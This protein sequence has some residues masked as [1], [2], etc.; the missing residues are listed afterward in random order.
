MERPL[1]TLIQHLRRNVSRSSDA[2]L[3]D[4]QLLERWTGQRDPAAFELLLWR[5]G[6]MVLNTCR[7]L[8]PRGEDAEDAFQA[9][10]LVFLRKGASLRRGDAL[11]AW[12]HRVAC[13]IALRARTAEIQ[14][15]KR[16]QPLVDALAAPH[17]D[18]QAARDLRAILDEEID[19]LPAHYRRALVLCCLEGKSQEEAAQML[20]CPRGTLSSWL[21]RGRERLRQR[22]LRRGIVVSSAGL[23]AALTSDALASGGMIPLVAS[24]IRVAGGVA[25][26]GLLSVRTI[27]L[28]EGMLRMMLMTKVKSVTAVLLVVVLLASG[29]GTIA[30]SMRAAESPVATTDK[31]RKT[32]KVPAMPPQGKDERADDIAWGAKGHGL[33]AG[34]GFRP[35]DQTTYEIGQSVTFVVYLRNVSDKKIALSHIE[36]LFNECMP[37]VEDADGNRLAVAH[38][39][40]NL[41]QVPIV[42]RSVKPGQQIT[43]GYPWFRIRELG[44]RGE[45]VGPTCGVSPGKYKVGYSGLLLRLNDGEDIGLGTK[46]VELVIRKGEAAKEV[47]PRDQAFDVQKAFDVAGGYFASGE[48]EKALHQYELIAKMCGTKKTALNALGETIRCFAVMGDFKRMKQRVE[49]IRGTLDTTEGLTDADRQ[50][51]LEWLSEVNKAL[52][53]FDPPKSSPPP[54]RGQAPLQR[55]FVSSRNIRIPVRILAKPREQVAQLILLVSRD[56][57]ETYQQAARISPT[58]NRFDFHAPGEGMY[59]FVVQQVDKQGRCTPANPSRV[60]PTLRVCVDTTRPVVTFQALRAEKKG[61]QPKSVILTWTASDANLEEKPIALVWADKGDG[62]WQTIDSGPLSNSGQ[63]TWHLPERL[64]TCVHVRLR[65]RDKAGNETIRDLSF[66]PALL[67]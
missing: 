21:T 62:P 54:E 14:R 33:Q 57:G 18:E 25:P 44:W 46:Q 31:E 29:V 48:H 64:P 32:K 1:Q 39:P 63:Y 42:N 5:H 27:A 17:F 40:I 19:R 36:P 45:V 28:A 38:G 53:T 37:T 30:H 66:D 55:F 4:A 24:L 61:N 7:R 8:L 12:L 60:K 15:S 16:Q 20:A 41:G 2:A 6:P 11:P 67:K 47:Q 3:T 13:R 10:F 50:Q 43:L 26:A 23:T 34:I 49:E 56:E 65:V 35:G 22:L 59:W 58:V 9:T 52:G 51:W